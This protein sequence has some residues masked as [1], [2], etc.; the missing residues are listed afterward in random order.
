M[1]CKQQ[2]AAADMLVLGLLKLALT[3][4]ASL[5]HFSTYVGNVCFS[6]CLLSMRYILLPLLEAEYTMC[7]RYV[8]T[9]S[10][11]VLLGSSHVTPID[12]NPSSVLHLVRDLE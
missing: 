8:L 9:A 12:M 2:S 3:I 7:M 1:E 10:F 6:F 5:Y 4:V 11:C